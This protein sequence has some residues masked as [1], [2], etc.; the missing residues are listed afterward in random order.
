MKGSVCEEGFNPMHCCPGLQLCSLEAHTTDKV[1]VYN[2]CLQ[3]A[4]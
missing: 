3:G 2:Q 1:V 4:S